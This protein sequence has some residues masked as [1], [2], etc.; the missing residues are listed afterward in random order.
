MTGSQHIV[1]PR[2]QRSDSV[3]KVSVVV[4]KGTNVVGEEGGIYIEADYGPDVIPTTYTSVARN[5]RARKLAAPEKPLQPQRYGWIAALFMARLGVTLFV[6]LMLV[7]LFF[8]SYPFL[9]AIYAQNNS[10]LISAFVFGMAI[11]GLTLFWAIRAG[12]QQSHSAAKWRKSYD[13]GVKAWEA[14]YARWN[15][16]YYCFHDDGVFLPGHSIF[17][18]AARVQNYL[19]A[20]IR[21]KNR[22]CN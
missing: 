11:I 8:C 17:V 9:A 15:Q 1:C 12:W 19:N 7:T 14:G 4:S 21:Q 2:C 22:T 16:L 5:A 10:L 18:P 3:Q 20:E 6:S 13:A